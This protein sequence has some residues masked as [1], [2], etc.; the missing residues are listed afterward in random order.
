MI[1]VS[2]RNHPERF[3]QR[4][5]AQ[6]RPLVLVWCIVVF[7]FAGILD[8]VDSIP[9]N[10][11]NTWNDT[12]EKVMMAVVLAYSSLCIWVG[13]M[14]RSI[15]EVVNMKRVQSVTQQYVQQSNDSNEDEDQ[16]NPQEKTSTEEE[17]KKKKSG[18]F[19]RLWTIGG[20]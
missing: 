14:I 18:L 2:A 3:S 1:L 19:G 12:F 11:G 13:Y 16:E 8:S 17:S 7:S 20:E 4:H 10:I 15:I 5:L 9:F 6:E